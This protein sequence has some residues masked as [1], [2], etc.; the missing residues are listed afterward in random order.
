MTLQEQIQ[1]I[2]DKMNALGKQMQFV[3]NDM[4]QLHLQLRALKE[5]V[6][7]GDKAANTGQI[8]QAPSVET[9]VVVNA[10]NLAGKPVPQ[11]QAIPKPN[12]ALQPARPGVSFENFV[13]LRLIHFIGIIVLVIGLAIGVKYA[14]DRNLISPLARIALAY[15]AGAALLFFSIRLQKKYALF[16][17]ILFSGAMASLYFTTYAAFEYY[18][19]MPRGVCFGLMLA[20]TI[21]TVWQSL[22]LN[23][24]AIAVLALVGAYAI[25]FLVGKESGRPEM[26]F[27]YITLINA[28]ILFL[29][30]KK[31]WRLL[32]Y[33][34]QFFTWFIFAAWYAFG[35]DPGAHHENIAFIFTIIFF[36]L[37]F[38]NALSYKVINKEPFVA[39]DVVKLIANAVIAYIFLRVIVTEKYEGDYAGIFTLCFGAF[40]AVVSILLGRMQQVDK[41]ILLLLQGIALSALL[42]F[43]PAQYAGT[44]TCV[45]WLT[46]A[47]VLFYIGRSRDTFF[48]E[49]FAYAA[50]FFCLLQLQVLWF[51]W[52][53]NDYM[54][55]DFARW[56]PIWNEA[57][58]LSLF[59]IAAL[60]I[61]ALVVYRYP[62]AAERQKKIP[63]LQVANYII[64]ILLIGLLYFTFYNEIKN[65]FFLQY[66]LS[67]HEFKL[68]YGD[69]EV[70]YDRDWL[71]L[72]WIWHICYMVG[73]AAFMHLVFVMKLQNRFLRGAVIIF[74]LLA[75]V[76]FFLLGLPEINMLRDNYLGKH[77][78]HMGTGYLY[79][80]YA[81]FAL[82][83]ILMALLWYR[84]QKEP[85][86][87]TRQKAVFKGVIVP[88][89]LVIVCSTEIMHYAKLS[90]F[91]QKSDIDQAAADARRFGL[92]A[93]WAIFS[94]GMIALGIWKKRKMVRVFAIILFGITL[95]KLL[96]YDIA[97][98]STGYKIIAF[99]LLGVL[100]LVV[101]FLYQRFRKLIF[102]DDDEDGNITQAGT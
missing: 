85:A 38:T 37:F 62:P 6:R 56:K 71:K 90:A 28:A 74:G 95:V 33:L 73:F 8:A 75:I 83:T 7:M 82:V 13:G 35:S 21:V 51:D 97:N 65:Y 93:F 15:G 1:I 29:S 102:G 2:E 60:A 53:S 18:A 86:V 27:S 68:D 96:A 87:T 9:G 30:F 70:R 69:T 76:V 88:L 36:L 77:E 78:F 44:R 16:S 31:Y 42:L 48:Y 26:L 54:S 39:H 25:P 92:T 45:G 66:R 94:F 98:L 57:L 47:T 4:Y 20:F 58:G 52:Y 5:Q 99:I 23:S 61:M 12:P 63:F 91:E 43:F 59:T 32:G 89:V 40:H 11:K 100:L 101:S 14:I 10:P 19:L 84:L 72:K 34:A 24:Q 17:S 80:R 50:L 55:F 64:A 22:R 46:M 79:L 49:L 41:R 67:A 81:G 3:Q